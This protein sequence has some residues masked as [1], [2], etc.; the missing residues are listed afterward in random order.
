MIG[1]L[2]FAATCRGRLLRDSE[3][4]QHLQRLANEYEPCPPPAPAREDGGDCVRVDAEA[5]VIEMMDEDASEHMGDVV[6][7][8]GQGKA[9]GSEE[10][11]AA[12]E[13]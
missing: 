7:S 1:D 9:A 10:P 11:E 3:L 5:G 12:A 8:Q 4:L 2:A 6:R 13:K